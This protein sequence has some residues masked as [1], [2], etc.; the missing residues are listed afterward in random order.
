MKGGI[1]RIPGCK[2]CWSG[3]SPAPRVCASLADRRAWREGKGATSLANSGFEI[4]QWTVPSRPLKSTTQTDYVGAAG[5]PARPTLPAK[6]NPK[7]TERTDPAL[8]THLA[9]FVKWPV[10]RSWV[11]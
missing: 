1:Q 8:S 9:D 3:S 11:G 5:L 10:R 6:V 4:T 7:D 2:G